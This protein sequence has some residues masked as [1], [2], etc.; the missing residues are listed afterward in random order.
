[1]EG[2]YFWQVSMDF[3]KFHFKKGAGVCSP[4]RTT[5]TAAAAAA[6]DGAKCLTGVEYEL[7]VYQ[8]QR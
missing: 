6:K 1:M 3:C 8:K 4:L 7:L 5:T 2:G